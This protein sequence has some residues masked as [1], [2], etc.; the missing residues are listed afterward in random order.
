MRVGIVFIAMSSMLGAYVAR[1][2][3]ETFYMNVPGIAGD[4]TARGF[5]GWITVTSFSEGFA[6]S[7]A[8]RTG[9][10]AARV[11]CQE[12]RIVKPLDITSP[13]LSL[14]VAS[15]QIFS[16]IKVAALSNGEKPV[17]F[18]TFTLMNAIIDSV[19]FGGD[20]DT[21]ARV[22]TLSIKPARVLISY[23]PQAADGTAG[24]PVQATIDCRP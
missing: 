15:D 10:G 9:G 23:K 18:L 17:E 16:T 1:A 22:E 24:T 19:Q 3:S 12:F 5:E 8:A 6:N 14:A 21:S 4:V 7:S 13:H 11:S 20:S 2:A